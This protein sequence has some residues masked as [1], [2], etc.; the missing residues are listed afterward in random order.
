MKTRE[1]LLTVLTGA[2]GLLAAGAIAFAANRVSGDEIGLSTAPVTVAGVE[3]GVKPE[4]APAAKRAAKH[5]SA[6]EQGGQDET[7]GATDD[8]SVA[9]DSN[10]GSDTSGS[11]TSGSDS[12]GSGSGSTV[13]PASDDTTTVDTSGGDDSSGSGSTSSGSGSDGS[14]SGSSGPD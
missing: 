6:D 12:S 10:Q 2:L 14:G 11:D 3:K 5:L 13:A 7:S 1:I 9:D 8:G 4:P